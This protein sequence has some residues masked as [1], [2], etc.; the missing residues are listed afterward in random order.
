MGKVLFASS[1]MGLVCWGIV[2][3]F[4]AQPAGWLRLL[5]LTLPVFCSVS[6]YW[7]LLKLMQVG[8]L[9]YIV[10]L[11]KSLDQTL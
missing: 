6:V 3:S 7:I 11:R 5:R 8:E 4:D 1:L 9:D 10:G 2:Q